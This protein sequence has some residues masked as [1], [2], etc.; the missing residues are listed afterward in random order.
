MPPSR[1]SDKKT[2]TVVTGLRSA[3]LEMFIF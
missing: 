3:V 2:M 1:K